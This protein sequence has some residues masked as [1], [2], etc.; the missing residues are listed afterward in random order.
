MYILKGD[1]ML[2]KDITII[3]ENF[4]PQE[5]MNVAVEG[6]KIAYIGKAL[7]EGDHGEVYDGRDRLLMPSF[8]NEH[9][10]LPMALMRGYGENLPLMNWLQDKI[11]PFEAHLTP[12]DMYYGTLFGIAEMLRYGIGATQEMY[13]NIESSGRAFVESGAK[14]CFSVSTSCF[15]PEDYYDL[16]V[17]REAMEGV[18]KYNSMGLERIRAELTLH[19]EYTT[20]EKVVRQLADTAFENGLSVHIHVSETKGE[21]EDCRSRHE[22]KSPVR[23][24]HDCGVFRNRTVAAHCVH[25]DEADMDILREDGVN[26]AT[27]PKSNAKL[28]SGICDVAALLRK[29]VNVAIGT[30]SVASNNNLNMLEEMR[31]LTLMQKATHNDPVVISTKELLYMATRAGAVAQGRP[32]SGLLKE[33][34][35]ADLTVFRTDGIC[36]KPCHDIIN[37]LIFSASGSDAVMTMVDGKVLYRDGAYPTLDMERIEYEIGRSKERILSEL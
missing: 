30:D 35:K 15:G 28:G 34:F 18:K 14:G 37:N 10:H 11:F 5:H 22:G 32:D 9:S 19:S 31:F 24:L 23:Y 7:P 27:C 3:D 20:T 17:Y 13:L 1:K 16:P 4:E 25:L 21:V 36:M 6:E 33:G 26:V 29:G 2:F 12:D 8:Y